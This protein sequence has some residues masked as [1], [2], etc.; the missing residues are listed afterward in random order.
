MN[1]LRVEDFDP[2]EAVPLAV[3][4]RASFE[5]GVGITDPHPIEEQITFLLEDLVP[6][7]TVRVA[8]QGGDIVGF[9][10][11]TPGSIAALYIRVENVGQGIGLHLLNL[12]KAQSSGSLWLY[13]FARNAR[14][15]RFYERNGFTEGEHGFERKWKLEDIK[16]QWLRTGT[17]QPGVAA[18]AP[19]A[20]R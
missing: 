9:S 13:T 1:D 6:N 7:N 5:F 3:M 17:S 8:K 20:R 19:A 10:A 2:A 15:R 11:S 12:A 4:W 16:Y 18:A 14:A